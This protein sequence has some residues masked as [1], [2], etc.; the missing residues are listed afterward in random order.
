MKLICLLRLI[1]IYSHKTVIKKNPLRSEFK[2]ITLYKSP[3]AWV[4]THLIPPTTM[5]DHHNRNRYENIVIEL[6]LRTFLFIEE[7]L[8]L[9]SI[10]LGMLLVLM[11]MSYV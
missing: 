8:G 9:K 6:L 5:V 2:I 11:I 3:Q 4:F 7:S 10:E 1:H